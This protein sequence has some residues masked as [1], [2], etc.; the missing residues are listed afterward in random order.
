MIV[1]IV[2]CRDDGDCENIAPAALPTG[3]LEP[4]HPSRFQ[5]GHHGGAKVCC[6]D[7]PAT[8]RGLVPDYQAIRVDGTDPADF[9]DPL[10]S[11]A[12]ALFSEWGQCVIPNFAPENVDLRTCPR[13]CNPRWSQERIQAVCSPTSDFPASCCPTIPTVPEDCVFIDGRWRAI[14]GTDVASPVDWITD[15]PGTRQDPELSGCHD[16]ATLPDGRVDPERLRDCVDQLTA[17]DGRG[18]CGSGDCPG[19]DSDLVDPCEA[20]NP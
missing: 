18:A 6:S 1:A 9:G 13:P 20:M 14:R 2:A 12:R 17:A 16:W 15:S 3:G 7:D 8:A 4:C 19:S 5:R 10:F 11:G